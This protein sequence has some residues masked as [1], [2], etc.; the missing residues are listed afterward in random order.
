MT[1]PSMVPNPANLSFVYG[2]TDYGDLEEGIGCEEAL[3]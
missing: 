2:L 1:N 3:V